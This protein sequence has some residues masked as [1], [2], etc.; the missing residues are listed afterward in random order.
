MYA[1][2]VVD[3]FRDGQ[4][5]ALIETEKGLVEC[6][7][8]SDIEDAVKFHVGDVFSLDMF[9]KTYLD[10]EFWQ[11]ISAPYK[12]TWVDM[13]FFH[14]NKTCKVGLY[15]ESNNEIGAI[16]VVAFVGV[17][18]KWK[19]ISHVTYLSKDLGATYCLGDDRLYDGKL[20]H[21]TLL[22]YAFL[23]LINCKN[24]QTTD[25]IPPKRLNVSRMK[26]GKCELFTYKTLVVSGNRGVTELDGENTG[27]KHRLHL[28]RGHFK[29]YT[30]EN[31]LFGRHTGLY[32]WQPMVRGGNRAGIVMKDY[33][34]RA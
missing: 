21:F 27:I 22:A 5:K 16:A 11:Y 14:N 33:E 29:R 34:V 13:S 19:I 3:W 1:H 30:T 10:R 25:N 23:V 2:Q 8:A 20:G 6:N 26:K 7:I 4:H 9:R 28:C 24:I 12:K 32:W 18:E 17:S 31:P 15:L